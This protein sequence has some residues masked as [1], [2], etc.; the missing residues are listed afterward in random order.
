MKQLPAEIDTAFYRSKNP[1]LAGFSDTDLVD[2]YWRFGYSE[3]RCPSPLA[4]REGLLDLV[5]ASDEVLEIGPFTVPCIRGPMVK[6]FDIMDRKGLVDRAMK[7]GYPTSNAPEIDFVSPSSDLSTVSGTYNIVFSCH[8]IEHQPD[9]VGH[10]NEVSS[11]LRPAGAYFLVVPD[12]RFIFDHYIPESTIA[13]VLEAHRERRR[14]HRLASVIE[15]RALVTH[16]DPV[17]HWEGDHGRTRADDHPHV[18]QAALGEYDQSKGSYIDVHAWQFTPL[19]FRA[20]VQRL[21]DLGLTPLSPV[22]VW[23]TPKPSMEFCAILGA[24]Q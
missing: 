2:H 8:C 18:I 19:S 20:I 7:L 5:E 24:S 12:K 16:N 11:L 10:L 17:R 6:Y 3:G 9:L 23:G 15:H 4:Q 1:D 14:V 21:N 22:R 13:G